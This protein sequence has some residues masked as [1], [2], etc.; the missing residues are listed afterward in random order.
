MTELFNVAT[1]MHCLVYMVAVLFICVV[2]NFIL[3]LSGL[4]NTI[5]YARFDW[6]MSKFSRLVGVVLLLAMIWSLGLTVYRIF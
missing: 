6:I 1:V 4:E 5:L 2:F 3:V